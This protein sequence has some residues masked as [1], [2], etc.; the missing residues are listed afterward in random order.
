[1]CRSAP[2]WPDEHPPAGTYYVDSAFSLNLSST[3]SPQ[4]FEG[5]IVA[6]V[7]DEEITYD[8]VRLF[9][10]NYSPEQW[11][12][13]RESVQPLPRA[14]DETRGNPWRPLLWVADSVRSGLRC[15]NLPNSVKLH[16]VS[17]RS[18]K[19]LASLAR[20]LAQGI[21]A[22]EDPRHPMFTLHW[23]PRAG[24]EREDHE[25]AVGLLQRWAK[26]ADSQYELHFIPWR[27]PAKSKV[28]RY[29]YF[30]L[31]GMWCALGGKITFT[32]RP[33]TNEVTGALVRFLRA[34]ADP[35]LQDHAL[36]PSSLKHVIKEA[37]K[38]RPIAP[39]RT[40]PRDGKPASPTPKIPPLVD[41]FLERGPPE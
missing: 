2:G 4:P 32:R 22:M 30:W 7:T 10:F 3:V 34:A 17:A 19:R 6:M 23:P 39:V 5:E 24:E 18:F 15:A 41:M 38:V 9:E 14:L 28:T 12:A 20:E 11:F 13:I 29:Y 16:Q 37:K 21:Q 31:I 33:E 35:V 1:V 25:E 27:S 36:K 26:L 8:G 40:L